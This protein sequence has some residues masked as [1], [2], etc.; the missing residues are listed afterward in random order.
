MSLVRRVQKKSATLPEAIYNVY[1]AKKATETARGVGSTTDISVIRKDKTRIDLD[2]RALD[3]LEAAYKRLAP[4]SL[5]QSDIDV[6][7]NSLPS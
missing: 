5:S 3:A 2:G 1:E 7:S 6:I 4:P